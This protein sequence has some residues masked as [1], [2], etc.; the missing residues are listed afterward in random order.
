MKIV[1]AG[2]AGYIGS[3]LVPILLEHGYELKIIDALWFGNYLPNGVEIVKK[4]L[5]DCGEDEFKDF[6]QLI[7]LAGLSNDPMAEFSP[8]L[9]FIHNAAL[10]SYLA[11][12]CKRV[13]I[14]RFIYAS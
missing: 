7:F 8:S 12:I 3:Y 13:G 10:P 11:Y 6:D 2:G 5:F 1:I 9:N 14:K 4:D